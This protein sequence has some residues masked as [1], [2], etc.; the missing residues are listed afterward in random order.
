LLIASDSGVFA[1]IS[2]I[3]RQRLIICR[4]AH[5]PPLARLIS[6]LPILGSA[7]LPE[8]SPAA[9]E[10]PEYRWEFAEEFLLANLEDGPTP[11]ARAQAG[12]AEAPGSPLYDRLVV[13]ARLP[14]LLLGALLGGLIFLWS[15]S[16]FGFWGGVLSLALYAFCP[17]ML[18]HASLAA[19]D[20]AAAFFAALALFALYGYGRHPGTGR[21]LLA[22]LAFGLAA[23][24]KFTNLLLLLPAGAFFPAPRLSR[25]RNS[26]RRVGK[27]ESV[28][29]HEKPGRDAGGQ[30]PLAHP[31]T[32]LFHGLVYLGIAWLVFCA[33]YFFTGLFTPMGDLPL[34][35]RALMAM[36]EALPWLPIPVPSA[37]LVGIDAELVRSENHLGIFYL[38]GEL[39]REGWLAYIPVA[40]AVKTPLPLLLLWMCSVPLAA[41]QF[42]GAG[43]HGGIIA[44]LVTP[45]LFLLAFILMTGTNYGLRY[46]LVCFPF[47]FVLSGAIVRHLDKPWKRLTLAAL[48][49]W[50]LA[51][52]VAVSPHYLTFF[53]E[54]AGGPRGGIDVLA[55]SNL[56]WGQQLKELKSYMDEMGLEEIALSYTGPVDPKVYGI[57][58]RPL[59]L[60]RTRGLAA[61]SANHLVGYFPMGGVFGGGIEDLSPLRRMKPEAVIANSLYLFRLEGSEGNRASSDSRSRGPQD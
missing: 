4:P 55:D 14:I 16:F 46:V 9:L 15:R 12:G 31:A 18:A 34:H 24:T 13:R 56:D 44:L 45:L 5:N 27:S 17:N 48:M 19:T 6:A 47:F 11:G 20:L 50:H 29:H 3:D 35:S 30:N 49:A 40:L 51:G 21:L 22:G 61:V 7:R 23:L 33:G 54:P 10:E 53:N 2:F 25:P 32:A 37:A 41:R 1:G 57:R 26:P 52:S 58:W 8:I 59:R 60:G 38:L 43:D 28:G 39:S 42:I 36:K